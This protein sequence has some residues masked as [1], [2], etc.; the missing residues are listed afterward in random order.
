MQAC[1]PRATVMKRFYFVCLFFIV[2]AIHLVAILTHHELITN[3]TKPLL[4]PLVT[5]FFISASLF[6]PSP[7]KPYIITA[8]FFSWI[9]DILLL[10]QTKQ[11]LFFIGGLVAFLI[12]HIFYILFFYRIWVNH[13]LKI[14]P[15]ILL[16]VIAFYAGL[17]S[18]LLPHLGSMLIPVIIYGFVISTMLWFALHMYLL[19]YKV[20]AAH[21]ISGAILFVIS[22]SALA[23]NKFYQP[24]P[25]A[26][27]IIMLTYAL[28][29]W[30]LI[31]GAVVYIAENAAGPKTP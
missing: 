6:T 29:Q 28:A 23:I 10:F 16:L 5:V 22:D 1:Y 3:I 25:A 13:Q 19:R 30:Q 20:A 27:F 8:L 9:G 18:F 7:L 2:L 11:A 21:F 17:I 12:A 31:R 26:S 24:F 15:L 4:I 14:R